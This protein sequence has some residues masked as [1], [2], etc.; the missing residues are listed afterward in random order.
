MANKRRRMIEGIIYLFSLP[1]GFEKSDF[2]AALGCALG[3]L[4]CGRVLGSGISLSDD[5]TQTIEVGAFDQN[6]A[7]DAIAKL[8]K[9]FKCRDI[10]LV[11]DWD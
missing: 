2:S 9:K 3:K 7:E 11:W 4:K 6:V 10:E 1:I 8:C 5:G